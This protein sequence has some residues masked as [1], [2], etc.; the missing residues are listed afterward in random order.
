LIAETTVW[1]KRDERSHSQPGIYDLQMN[2]MQVLSKTGEMISPNI[3]P[4]DSTQTMKAQASAHITNQTITEN[5][6]FL[7]GVNV[8][9]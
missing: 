6:F 7:T 2:S 8:E 3:V 4:T 1:I 5:N 9:A